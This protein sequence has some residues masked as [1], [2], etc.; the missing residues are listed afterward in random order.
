MHSFFFLQKF[1]F[2][3]GPIAELLLKAAKIDKVN[4]F[5]SKLAHK[6]HE[7]FFSAFI[8]ELDLKY[9]VKVKIKSKGR[10]ISLALCDSSTKRKTIDYFSVESF[11]LSN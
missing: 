6:K 1:G 2:L 5:Y 10:E 3:K 4:V 7:D 11:L 8:E 9:V